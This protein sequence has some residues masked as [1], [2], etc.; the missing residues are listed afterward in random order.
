MTFLEGQNGANLPVAPAGLALDRDGNLFIA[1]PT[2]NCIV[3]V[4]PSGTVSKVAGNGT[5]GYSGD[6]GLATVA[7]LDG[8]SGVAVDSDGNLYIAETRNVHRIRKVTPNGSIS[9]VAGKFEIQWLL[10]TDSAGN[11]YL[12]AG[13]LVQKMAA[14]GAIT[15]VAGMGRYQGF[16]GDGGPATSAGLKIAMDVAVD[17]AGNLYI[18]DL[19]NHRVRKVSPSGT[20]STVAGNGTQGYSGDGGPA[21]SAS[22]D[23]PSVVAVD[24]SGNLYIGDSSGHLRKVGTDGII[25]TV[26]GT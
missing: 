1:D 25:S 3:K 12:P 2:G 18:A 19:W 4:T 13:G 6:G 23:S 20:I 7:Q 21:T 22:L 17:A 9:T 15:T 10:A 8:P 26:P 5:A 16:W 24:S 11:L 14:N